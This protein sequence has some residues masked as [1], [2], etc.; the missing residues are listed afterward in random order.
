MKYRDVTLSREVR[1]LLEE[2]LKRRELAFQLG[3]SHFQALEQVVAGWDQAKAT[4]F[5]AE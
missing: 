3:F 5:E 2:A 4:E 1:D